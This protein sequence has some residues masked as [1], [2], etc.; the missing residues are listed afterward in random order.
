MALES[1]GDGEWGEVWVKLRRCFQT[2]F[3]R[4][5]T[6]HSVE[7]HAG[8]WG[9]SWVW[10]SPSFVC[11]KHR[12]KMMCRKQAEENM[13]LYRNQPISSDQQQAWTKETVTFTAGSLDGFCPRV[14]TFKC[15]LWE[16][17]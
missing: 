10:E 14:T 13:G 15:G 6:L 12:P 7:E 17:S 3:P 5:L 11:G 8:S 16:D 9:T 2:S 4:S 1:A